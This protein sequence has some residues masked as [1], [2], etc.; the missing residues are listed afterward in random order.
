MSD[1]SVQPDPERTYKASFR[2]Y[3]PTATSSRGKRIWLYPRKPSGRFYRARTWVST[4]LLL[5]LFAGP[6][7]KI[8]GNPLLMMNIV[9]RRFSLFGQMFW[10]QDMYIFALLM[11]VVF[12]MIALSTAAYGR[13]W[14]GWLCPQTVLMEMVF[15]KIEYAI[16]G[17]S[18][19]QQRLN[20]SP[21]T[22]SKTAKKALK[23]SVFFALSFVIGNLLLSYIV[24]WEALWDII[25]DSPRNHAKGLSTMVAFSLLFYAIFARFR[26]QACTFI[27]PYGRLQ[28]V[29]LDERSIIVAYDNRR[30][31]PAGKFPRSQTVEERKGQGIGDCINCGLCV[32]VCPTGI[33]IRNGTQMECVNCTACIDACDGV[34]RKV[35]L[36]TG[37]VR[38]ASMLGI[39]QGEH[40]KLTPRLTGYTAVLALLTGLLGVLLI[41]RED[42]S[43]SMLRTPGTLYQTLPTGEISNLYL[44]KVT[45]K[46]S[47]EI[48]VTLELETPSDAHLEI[49]G[50]TIVAKASDVTESAIVVRMPPDMVPWGQARIVV[51]VYAS[52]K[53]VQELKSNFV[54]PPPT[55]PDRREAE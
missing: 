2:N 25:T 54:G 42:V 40:L 33:D 55:S 6:F 14:C 39:E 11:L 15:R 51:G 37:L 36:P 17:D 46:S 21:W 1:S 45:N 43:A 7:I 9:E 19:Q 30:G 47:R 18:G 3:I 34:M 44:F 5:I 4:I 29:L 38:Y 10:P 12:V 52:G 41:G 13:V 23:H 16:E 8:N 27:C 22:L 28:S 35:G 24:G 48:P 31:E 50:H 49:A 26:E 32:A 20:R 53:R